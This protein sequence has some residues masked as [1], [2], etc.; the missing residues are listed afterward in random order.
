MGAC[1]FSHVIDAYS[2]REGFGMLV[3]EAVYECGN[4]GY[5]GTISTCSLG[6]V[7]D[8]SSS[9][10]YTK[11]VMKKA[12]QYIK[13][14]DYGSK[15]TATCLDLGIIGYDVITA[16]KTQEKPKT[17]AEYRQKYVVLSSAL[18]SGTNISLY[19]D[20]KKEADDLAMQLAVKNNRSYYVAKRPVNVN[21]GDDLVTSIS[22]T[23]TRKK[24]KP[25]TC[26]ANSVIKP[27]HKYMYYGWAAC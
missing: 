19:R 12:E 3:S 26:P 2:A 23:T 25:K 7:R 5:N 8:L 24:T 10:N 13:D 16:K 20:T 18:D 9:G 15:W 6:A 21:R 14:D 4:D 17:K 27:V 22:Y 1:N 11:A